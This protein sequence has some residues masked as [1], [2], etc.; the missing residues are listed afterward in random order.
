MSPAKKQQSSTIPQGIIERSPVIV[1][2]GHIDH[3]KST[4]LDYIREANVVDGE[5]GGI[6]QHVSAYEVNHTRNGAT[7]RITFLDT[8][9]HEAFGKI[10]ARGATVADIAILVVSAEDGVKPQTLDALKAIREAKLSFIVAINKIDKP[11]ANIE[12]T[13]QNL[14]ENDI[15]VEGYGGDVPWVAISAKTGEGIPDLLD[16]MLLV[17]DVADLKGD[18]TQEASGSIIESNIDAKKGISAT[19]II[20]NG[21]LRR[22]DCVV[23]GDA[24]A[25]VRIIENF[26]GKPV[27]EAYF[28][29][30]VQIIGWSKLPQVGSLFVTVSDKKEAE[31]LSKQAATGPKVVSGVNANPNK[32]LGAD[33]A[34]K[35]IIP[36]IIKADATGSLEGIEHELQKISHEKVAVQIIHSGI[37]PIAESDVKVAL[38]APNSLIIAFHVKTDSA[39]FNLADRSAIPIKTFDIIYKIT[40]YIMTLIEERKPAPTEEFKGSA[41]VLKVFSKQKDKQVLGARMT[42][43]VLKLGE[44][45]RIKRRDSEIATGRIKNL[46]HMKA[47]V[48]EISDGKEFGTQIEVRVELAYGDIIESVKILKPTI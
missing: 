3:G 47:D 6:T 18:T 20:K 19:M 10:R 32:Q 7:R 37:G 33:E 8:P 16:M 40:E 26:L 36:L 29:T 17:A 31:L 44:M 27:E 5:A 48:K 30:P 9:G 28:S 45:V 34:A 21:T 24:W 38:G 23:A 46:Q 15:Y 11:G 39:A 4:L 22:G 35:I 43:G 1:I 42:D 41:M 14:A 25:P 12:R 13:K 2:M